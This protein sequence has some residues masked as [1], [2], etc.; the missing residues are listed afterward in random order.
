MLAIEVDTNG[1]AKNLRI[2][3]GLG[4]GLDEK[5]IEA[6]TR[7]RFRP[8]AED[9]KPVVTSATVEVSFHLL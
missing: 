3:Q 7:W 6:V 1:R 8:G 5:A 2:L 9:G 4:L